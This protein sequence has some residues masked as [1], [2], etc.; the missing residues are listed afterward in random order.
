[1][2][3]NVKPRGGPV[4][5][6]LTC[7]AE[8]QSMHRHDWVACDCD[9]TETGIFIDGGSDYTRYGVGNKSKWAWLPIESSPKDEE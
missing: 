1:M 3:D 7:G 6:C 5:K 9:S 2:P 4:M 8:I